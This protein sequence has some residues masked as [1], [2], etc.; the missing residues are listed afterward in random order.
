[1]RTAV[2]TVMWSEPMIFAP[3]NGCFPLYSARSAIKPGISCSAR[4]ISFRP[5]S[6]RARSFTL[7]GSRPA[8]IAAANEFIGSVIMPTVRSIEGLHRYPSCGFA[9][10]D[11]VRFIAR[12]GLSQR[13][14]ALTRSSEQHRTL[15]FGIRRQR[16]VAVMFEAGACHPVG[17][18][19]AVET[20]PEMSH[21]LPQILSA[22]GHHVEHEQSSARLDHARRLR[23]NAGRIGRV[24]KDQKKKSHVDLAIPDRQRFESAHS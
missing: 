7:Y 1:M 15:R 21:C 23:K 11:R 20:L 6:A 5:N 19:V 4:R 24:V 2:C 18:G 10:R 14:G 16:R 13:C 12:A 22:V 17:Q 9:E 3:A 8:S